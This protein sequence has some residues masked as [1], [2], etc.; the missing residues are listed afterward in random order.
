MNEPMTNE[1]A[2]DYI[3]RLEYTYCPPHGE[4]MTLA[5]AALRRVSALEAELTALRERVKQFEWQPIETAPKDERAILLGSSGFVAEGYR[6]KDGV[7]ISYCIGAL[8]S[9][10]THWMP[11]P[12]P[13]QTKGEQ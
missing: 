11:L 9:Q 7:F 4:P 3:E 12:P 8:Y 13:P 5:V 1:Q 10:V 2:A 6:N